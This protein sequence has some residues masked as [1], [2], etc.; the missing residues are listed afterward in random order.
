MRRKVVIVIILCLLAL[1]YALLRFSPYPNLTA[2]LQRGYSTRIYDAEENLL[3]ILPLQE[4]LRR[5]WQNYEKIPENVRKIFVRSEDKRFFYHNGVDYFAIFSAFTQ[6]FTAQK[7]VRGA[8]TITMQLAKMI[9][10]ENFNTSKNIP[11]KNK[12]RYFQKISDV[13]NAYRLETRFSKK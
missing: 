4:G 10:K 13:I 11:P 2:F 5:E 6:N 8:S 12:N 7:T 1:P 3:Q 9:D